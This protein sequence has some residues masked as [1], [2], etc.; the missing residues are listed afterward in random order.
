MLPS[1]ICTGSNRYLCSVRT[2][3]VTTLKTAVLIAATVQT[4]DL[5]QVRLVAE[6]EYEGELP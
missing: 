5:T 3:D 6:E 2:L 4:P 1:R